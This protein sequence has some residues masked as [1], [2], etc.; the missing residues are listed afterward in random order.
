MMTRRNELARE[1]GVF[2]YISSEVAFQT[3][4]R[5]P[6]VRSGDTRYRADS[7]SDQ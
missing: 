7:L 5:Q 1:E 4:S 3:S 6:C 2:T